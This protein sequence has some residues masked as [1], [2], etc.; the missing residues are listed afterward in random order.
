MIS[1]VSM[2]GDV[3]S[4]FVVQLRITSLS[5]M[6]PSKCTVFIN[7]YTRGNPIAS[8]AGMQQSARLLSARD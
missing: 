1:S 6:Q 8:S 2:F 7:P 5:G 4:Q 3:K